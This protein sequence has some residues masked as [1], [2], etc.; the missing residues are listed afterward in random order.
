MDFTR[1]MR[2]Q[3]EM[4]KGKAVHSNPKIEWN[5]DVPIHV[6]FALRP[7]TGDTVVHLMVNHISVWHAFIQNDAIDTMLSVANAL[8]TSVA[9]AFDA[10]GVK[11]SLVTA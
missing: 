3:V 8:A 1:V 5:E 10:A 9:L 6:I 4:A 11:Y 7:S 2:E